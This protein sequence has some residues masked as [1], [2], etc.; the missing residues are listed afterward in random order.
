MRRSF[1][2]IL[3]VAVALP[4]VSLAAA[5]PKFYYGAWL[6]FWQAQNGASDVSVNLDKLQEVS[7][8]SYEISSSGQ[9]I[10][11]LNIGN[12]S[13][14]AWFSSARDLGVKIIPT[15]A[16]FDGGS[17]LKLMKNA[18]KRQ[19]HEDMIAAL[20]KS[21]NFDGID[22]DYEAKPAEIR[23][24]FSLFIQG[25]AQRLHP[26]H[27]TLTCTVESRTPPSD[28]TVVTSDQRANNYVVLNQYCD[29]VR[30]MAYDQGLI[31]RQLD[32]AKGSST[33]YAP[34]ADPLWVSKVLQQALQWIK[35]GKIMLGVPTYGYEYQVTW[36]SGV[37]TYERVRSFTYTQAMDRADEIGLAP[38][39][40][41]AGELSLTFN[42]TTVV[43]VPA[44][45]IWGVS[46][47][48]PMA[49]ATVPVNATNTF[50]ISFSDAQ[51]ALDKINLAKKLKLRGVIF[52]KADGMAD[53]GIWDMLN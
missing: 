17:M 19:A 4:L 26:M 1:L 2:A 16:W 37:T 3:L 15:V 46:S 25:L 21:E 50:Y 14:D 41:S 39:R 6:P 27:K 7:P 5:K 11:D 32:T 49:L 44:S 20:V 30:V 24:Y 12:G 13:W 42:S 35:P 33:L 38:V 45:L 29:E 48:L 28:G 8:F 47:T 53:P 36:N 31:D 34:V 9:L 23:P 18:K 51:S 52:F 10:D 22:I 40:N 43:Q